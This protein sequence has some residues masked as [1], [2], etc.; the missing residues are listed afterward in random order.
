MS[1]QSKNRKNRER[2]KEYTRLHQQGQKGPK[3]TTPC[4]G[5]SADRRMYSRSRRGK[6]DVQEKRSRTENANVSVAE[7]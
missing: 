1:R 4:H 3:A 5:K 2:A 7:E 6:K